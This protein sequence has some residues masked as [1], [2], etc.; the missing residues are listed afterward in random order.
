MLTF[1]GPEMKYRRAVGQIE[2]IADFESE[3]IIGPKY[4]TAVF[5]ILNLPLFGRTDRYKVGLQ[6]NSG[7]STHDN[8]SRRRPRSSRLLLRMQL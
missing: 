2:I 1:G 4:F 8:S 6:L 5:R 3:K 7:R